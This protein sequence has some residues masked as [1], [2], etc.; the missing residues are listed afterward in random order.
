MARSRTHQQLL[1]RSLSSWQLFVKHQQQKA[2]AD[3]YAASRLQQHVFLAWVGEACQARSKAHAAVN[4]AAR[5]Q[6]RMHNQLLFQSFAAWRSQA[7]QS[8]ALQVSTHYA[9]A[10]NM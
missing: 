9:A 8:A 4:M 7:Q 10:M 6:A 2:T 3:A 5:V 1:R